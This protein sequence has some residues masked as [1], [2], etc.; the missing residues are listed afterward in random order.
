MR[1]T[2]HPATAAQIVAQM[3]YAITMR[4]LESVMSARHD[5]NLRSLTQRSRGFHE[6]G[7][8]L[9]DPIHQIL[10]LLV[11]RRRIGVA[12]R[13]IDAGKYHRRIAVVEMRR[14]LQA[15][16]PRA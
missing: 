8:G 13:F 3:A 10:D 14:K 7:A 11:G 4:A 16:E 1:A 12:N 2:A 15:L 9:I 5:R 6:G